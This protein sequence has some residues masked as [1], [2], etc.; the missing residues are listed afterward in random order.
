MRPPS[1][2]FT[3]LLLAFAA[4]AAFFMYLNRPMWW[5]QADPRARDLT[6][7]IGRAHV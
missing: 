1:L 5:Q 6:E 2:G 7:E 4:F 3:Y